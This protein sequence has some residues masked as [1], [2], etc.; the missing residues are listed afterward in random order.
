M[1]LSKFLRFRW[2]FLGL[3]MA[4]LL[5][6]AA[7]GDD[8][9]EAQGTPSAQFDGTIKIGV[10]ADLSGPGGVSVSTLS[11]IAGMNSAIKEINANGGVKVA[12]KSYKMEVVTVD[13]RAD[14]TQAVAAAQQLIDQKVHAVY[15]GNL[16]PDQSYQQLKDKVIS[17]SASPG[18]TYHIDSP[19]PPRPGEGPD[20]HPLL[21]SNIDGF[22]PIV[23]AHLKMATLAY[24]S[25]QKVG[26]LAADSP[27]GVNLT[28]G[29][30]AAAQQV[31]LQFVGSVSVPVGST[32]VA[33]FAT[34]MKTRGADFVF[35]ATQPNI[36]VAA[37]G[38]LEAN[39]AKYLGGWTIRP[40]DIRTQM[41]ALG[42][43][44]F[45]SPD[46]RLP[47]HKGLVPQQY[48]QAVA[49]LEDL[50][51]GEPRHTGWAISEWDWM[52]LLKQAFEK[53]GTL[54]D[55]RA[56]ATALIGQTYQGPFGTTTVLPNHTARGTIGMSVKDGDTYTVYGWKD[57]DSVL[58]GEQPLIK[59][60]APA[61]E[62]E[63]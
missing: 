43:T 14:A 10:I 5:T 37:N 38:A 8:E 51:G 31:G 24:P 53:A 33:P 47:F 42:S 15:L 41:R 34:T 36:V 25:I 62:V 29:T 44:V 1:K 9:E 27:F 35:L 59:F 19:G 39:M 13:S 3:L 63:R 28:R 20:N 11:H 17:W 48:Q 54:D 61:A 40:F 57:I 23:A 50:P 18:V 52:Y 12:G 21:F 32:D 26:I 58:K 45:I 56:I 16:Q 22:A 60:S 46:W 55:P 2:L 7:C 4:A 30:E 6:A 49:K